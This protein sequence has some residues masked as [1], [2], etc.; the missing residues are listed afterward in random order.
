MATIVNGL[1]ASV[2]NVTQG[3]TLSDK[4]TLQINIRVTPELRDCLAEFAK[5]DARTLSSYINLVLQA[6]VQQRQST[7]H[8]TVKSKRR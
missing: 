5:A 4:R 1:T 6:H 8:G 7:D 2:H 3:F